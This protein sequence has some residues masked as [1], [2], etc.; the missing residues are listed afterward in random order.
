MR[1]LTTTRPGSWTEGGATAGQPTARQEG[2]SHSRPNAT[3]SNVLASDKASGLL[4]AALLWVAAFLV[5]FAV[6]AIHDH[7]QLSALAAL[8]AVVLGALAEVTE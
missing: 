7:A 6:L 8:G 1:R 3:K 2:V 5:I 4:S